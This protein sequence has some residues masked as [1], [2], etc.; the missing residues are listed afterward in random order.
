MYR[1]ILTLTTLL[2]I[3]FAVTTGEA[4]REHLI[5]G[6]TM[7]TTYHVRVIAGFFQ[8][9]SGL[10]K[11]IDQRLEEINRS[12]STYQKDSEI[13]RFNQFKQAG[14]KFKISHDFFNLSET[15]FHIEDN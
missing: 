4:K 13:S 8:S 15:L 7:G 12:L 9:V 6:R 10:Q 11:R 2:S 5:Q 14:K 1:I 3:L